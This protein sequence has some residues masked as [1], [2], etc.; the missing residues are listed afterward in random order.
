M[1]MQAPYNFVPLSEHVVFPHWGPHVSLDLPFAD[2]ESGTLTLSIEAH[3]PIFVRD[4]RKSDGT[5]AFAQ[6]DGRYFLPGSSLKGMIRNVMEIMTFSKLKQATD[7]RLAY[8]DFYNKNLYKV[9]DMAKTARCGWLYAEKGTFYLDKVGEPGRVSLPEIDRLYGSKLHAFF[10][11]KRKEEGFDE[12]KD[13]QKTAVFKY[14]KLWETAGGQQSLRVT[15]RKRAKADDDRNN[16]KDSRKLYDLTGFAP[17]G[18]TSLIADSIGTLVLTGQPSARKEPKGNKP[19]GKIYEFIF[20]DKAPTRTPVP[21]QVVADLYCAYLDHK[22]EEEQSE[23]WK[24][25]K[26]RL[27]Q[28]EKVPVFYHEQNNQLQSVGL[29][30]LYKMAYPQ[31]V[32]E[33]RSSKH[34]STQPD[35]T[36]TILGY[37]D[38]DGKQPAR[39]QVDQH[40]LK[41]RV[42]FGHAWAEKGTAQPAGEPVTEIL[43]SPKASYYPAYVRQA[44]ARVDRYRTYADA[45][46]RL[47]GWKRYPVQVGQVASYPPPESVKDPTKL[48]T[49][50][51]PLQKGAKFT[52]HIRYHNLRSIELGALVSALTL[53]HT[54]NTYHSL[55]L[56]KALGYGKV[57]LTVENLDRYCPHLARFEAY[58]SHELQEPFT[59]SPQ[60]VELVSMATEQKQAMPELRYMSIAHKSHPQ[61]EA[62]NEFNQ[63]KEKGEALNLY[64]ELVG[65]T[66]RDVQPLTDSDS[67]Q[68]MADWLKQDQLHF[69]GRKERQALVQE[70]LDRSRAAAEAYLA[71]H[72]QRLIEQLRARRE[73]VRSARK[74]EENQ[75]KQ[76]KARQSG[77]DY[78]SVDPSQPKAF[79]QLKRVIT[80]YREARFPRQKEEA[81]LANHPTGYLDEAYR[82]TL[83]ELVL[84]HAQR[85]GKKAR[86]K[87]RKDL[88]KKGL[89]EARLKK[90]AEWIGKEEAQRFQSSLE[91]VL[92]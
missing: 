8:R 88:D 78:A 59:Q 84:A 33:L 90:L 19:S 64:T 91:Q 52:C 68:A 75:R 70:H 10:A 13:E 48:Q 58:M 42:H 6:H 29:S 61:A 26:R 15:A 71:S 83:K 21:P 80:E 30:L 11:P 39:E 4:G 51:R 14:R 37:V 43:S 45:L 87:W 17:E 5:Q 20:W 46:A 79:E 1:P 41:G 73:A 76:D 31:S 67:I 89:R 2:Q 50:F 55:G 23:D 22:K 56:A 82:P 38:L 57:K 65:V 92:T 49:V 85:L 60:I 27:A 62:V 25:C 36:E 63:V 53:H 86:Q 24:D 74:A 47:A 77:P 34:S 81:V 40:A 9:S 32:H 12:S 35:L 16:A 44:G 69:T 54:S 72:Q 3:S 28:G 7:E 66:P 18:D